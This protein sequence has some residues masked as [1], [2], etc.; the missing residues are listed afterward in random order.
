M[1][2][3]K[4]SLTKYAAAALVIALT[5]PAMIPLF[6]R[7]YFSMHDDQQVVRLYELD[8]AL[9]AGQFPVH[10][11]ADLGFGFGY[12]LFIFY[13]PL[14]YY[15]GEIYHLLLGTSFIDS[16]KLVFMSAFIAAAIAMYIWTKEHFGKAGAIIA[17]AFYTYAPYHAVDA[18]VR[19][20]LA[21]LAAFVWIPLIFWATDRLILQGKKQHWIHLGIFLSLSMITHNLILLPFIPFWLLY[22]GFLLMRTQHKPFAIRYTLLSALLAAG[23]SAFFW[24]PA[25]VERKYTLVDSIL[26]A[27]LA[28]YKL[29]FVYP[30]QLWNSLWGYG[31]SS[32]GLLDGLSFKI[33]KLHVALTLLAPILCLIAY[34][35][36]PSSQALQPALYTSFLFLLFLLATFMTI[37]SSQPIWDIIKPLQ[38]LQF[39]WRFLLLSA[40]FSSVLSGAVVSLILK[41]LRTHL[42]Q[43]VL[44]VAVLGLLIYPNLKLFRPQTYLDVKD[45][46]ILNNEFMQWTVS[47]TSFEFVPREVK[48]VAQWNDVEKQDVT[49]VAI[50]K[51]QLP[52]TPFTILSGSGEIKIES[53]VPGI[54]ALQT[55][56]EKDLEIRLNIFDFPGW[57]VAIDGQRVMP[58]SENDLK[59]LSIRVP[60]GEHAVSVVFHETS[61]RKVGNFITLT[62]ILILAFT[63]VSGQKIFSRKVFET[64]G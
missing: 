29:H 17:S 39:P 43:V 57:K 59:L 35:Q 8:R 62:T 12:P 30:A 18:Y 64:N 60:E 34:R 24:I 5:L 9:A 16:T 58:S 27:D 10:W 47:K 2:K 61:I 55:K 28:S 56:S 1:M 4:S 25:L 40:V 37:G 49:Q 13:P 26:L 38:Y 19:G 36:K 63:T 52:T 11:V 44:S 21:E 54:L 23:L 7:G 3:E 51:N 6:H 14:V 46:N 22:V 45:G 53:N 33:G 42:T 20:A 50:E 31:G 41:H 15:L 48:T 32:A